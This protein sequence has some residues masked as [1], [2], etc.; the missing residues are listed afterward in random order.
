MLKPDFDVENQGED[1]EETGSGYDSMLPEGL[2]VLEE[3]GLAEASE[4]ETTTGLKRRQE[5]ADSLMAKPPPSAMLTR[6][7]RILRFISN[8]LFAHVLFEQRSIDN[9]RD[10]SERGD[11]VYVMQTRSLLDYLYFNYAFLKHDLPIAR[12]ANSMNMRFVRGFFYWLGGFFRRRRKEKPEAQMEALV[13]QGESAFIFLR[14]P[15]QEPEEAI[16]FSQKY[17]YRLVRAQ[18]SSPRPIYVIPLLLIWEK[19]PEPRRP[20]FLDDIFGTVQ[21]PGFFRKFVHYFQT[22]WQSFLRFGQPLVQVSSSINVQEFLREYPNTGSSEAS[23]LLRERLDDHINQERQVILGPTGV[24]K[25]Q[26][27][28]ELMVRPELVDK[29]REVA[30]N[31]GATEEEVR[32]RARK[33][34]EEIAAEPS[35]L[36]LKIFNSVLSLVWYRIYDGFEVDEEGIEEVRVAARS[37]S[38]VLIPSHKSHIDYL[39]ISYIFYQYGL[40]PPHIAAGA[41]LSFWPMGWIFRRAGAFFL[42]RSFKGDELYPVMFR[43]YLIRLMEESHPIEFFIEG[44]RSRT[45]KL[46]KPRYGML[47]MMI[48]AYA[49]GRVESVKIVPISVGYEKIIE[50]RSF[51]Q[52]LL[53]EEK[54]KESLAGLLKTPK[55][56]TSKYGRLYVE[57]DKPIDLGEY[58]EKYEIPRLR[59]DDKDLDELTVRLAHRII[60]DINRVTTVS[61]TALAATVLLNNPVRGTDRERFLKEVGFVLRFLTDPTREARLSATLRDALH[62]SEIALADEVPVDR[63]IGEAVSEVMDRALAIFEANKQVRVTRDEDEIFYGMEDDARL[64]LSFYRNT[65]VHHFVPEG[66]LATAALSFQAPTID[67]DEVMAETLFLSRLF[68]HEWIYEERAEFENVFARTLDY[69]EDTGLVEVEFAEEGG[70][71]LVKDNPVELEYFRRMVLTFV[72]AYAIVASFLDELENAPWEEG[73][74]LKEALKRGRADY[75]RGKILFYESI[76]KPT[77]KNALRL[78]TDWGVLIKTS[79]PGRKRDTISYQLSDAWKESGRF[80]ELQGKLQSFV[81]QDE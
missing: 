47:D 36:M 52:E 45:G 2:P 22:G 1:E 67:L 62:P 26:I 66:L 73:D 33:Q 76:S 42:R 46:I 56:L 40:M 18:K 3:E 37:S 6:M 12:F 14:K 49:H 7:R 63:I 51:R 68:K 20:S 60:Y 61:P 77:F 23:E 5:L 29:I 48:R 30:K 64:E 25:E 65:L 28:R 4:V 58:M 72:E 44:T 50:E 74:L 80:E 10:A 15:R 35:L 34:F 9:I 71:I 13:H 17:I 24:P 81:Y 27:F 57:F 53:G 55:F 79:E 75:L 39:V 32:K 78:F 70:C 16:E 69:F 41:N 8:L 19:R 59:P 54:E 11:V 43:E 38:L 21:S 31:E